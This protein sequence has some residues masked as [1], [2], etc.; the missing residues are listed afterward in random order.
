MF[1]TAPL[2]LE[3]G[4]VDPATTMAAEVKDKTVETVS[5][6]DLFYDAKRNGWAHCQ[7]VECLFASLEGFK[8]TFSMLVAVIIVPVN[9]K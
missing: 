6:F 5:D 4:G 2:Q 9:R 8:V 1:M 3:C 7:S